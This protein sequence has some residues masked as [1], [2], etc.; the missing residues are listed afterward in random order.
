[1]GEHEQPEPGPAPLRAWFQ[2]PLAAAGLG[3]SG[4]EMP[5][6]IPATAVA[7]LGD[8]QRW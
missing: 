3:G 1:V 5:S 7:G 6:G 2:S 8:F 4:H